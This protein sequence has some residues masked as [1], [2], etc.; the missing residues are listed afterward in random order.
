MLFPP[1]HPPP[2]R[3][4]ETS[5]FILA[6][7]VFNDL[8]ADGATARGHP[9]NHKIKENEGA[10]F[11]N[12]FFAILHDPLNLMFIYFIYKQFI[13]DRTPLSQ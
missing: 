13:A 7:V 5:S 6:S 8:A 1:P 4:V 3:P 9:S 12:T 11:P 2:P 10:Y